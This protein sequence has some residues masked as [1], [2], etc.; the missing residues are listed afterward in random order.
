MVLGIRAAN[1]IQL[2]PYEFGISVLGDFLNSMSKFNPLS[3]RETLRVLLSMDAH[4]VVEANNGAEAFALFRAGKF[5]LVVTD[6]EMPFVKGNEL[7]ARIKKLAPKQPI[8]MLTAYA[9]R[10]GFDNPVDVVLT[11]PFDSARLREIMSGLLGQPGENFADAG[12]AVLDQV[13]TNSET[14]I[15]PA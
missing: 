8:L 6:F 4:T 13:Q 7:A 15:I 2:S 11:K 12:A 5:D 14:E 3:V 1:S 10:R 9:Q